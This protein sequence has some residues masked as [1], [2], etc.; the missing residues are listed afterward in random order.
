MNEEKTP[1]SQIFDIALRIVTN[2]Y[3]DEEVNIEDIGEMGA[4]DAKEILIRS[5]IDTDEWVDG[6]Q[7]IVYTSLKL[8]ESDAEKIHYIVTFIYMLAYN[9]RSFIDETY[10]FS[11][12]N[13]R[14]YI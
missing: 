8:C 12:K 10:K 5:I 6:A 14:G 11:T 2:L 7:E 1:D 4:K 3:N 9:S 13:I